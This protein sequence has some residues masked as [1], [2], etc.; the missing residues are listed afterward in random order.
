MKRKQCA[1]RE[2]RQ[3]DGK[4]EWKKA[5]KGMRK[6]KREPRGRE[7]AMNGKRSGRDEQKVTNGRYANNEKKPLYW[8]IGILSRIKGEG[9]SASRV[10]IIR[11]GAAYM[12]RSCRVRL[13]LVAIR[14]VLGHFN[15]V[16]H[17]AAVGG[18]HFSITSS[19]IWQRQ[20]L[21][22]SSSLS[23]L[24]SSPLSPSL[25]HAPPSAQSTLGHFIVLFASYSRN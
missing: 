24:L 6:E 1:K 4:V 23:H 5:W 12:R 25:S 15:H 8:E 14:R 2:R 7:E 13:P 11:G 10:R 19:N 18:R 17:V 21:S 16:V 3:R 20:S 9:W 22:L